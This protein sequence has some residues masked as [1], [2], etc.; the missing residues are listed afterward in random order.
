MQCQDE[1]GKGREILLWIDVGMRSPT[2]G[3]KVDRS[4]KGHLQ[5][6]DGWLCVN[7]SLDIKTIEKKIDY[8]LKSHEPF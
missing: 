6:S 4:L 2:I 7:S 5:L 3:I 8:V 1:D